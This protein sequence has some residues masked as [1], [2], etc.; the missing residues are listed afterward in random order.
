MDIVSCTAKIQ[1]TLEISWPYSFGEKATAADIYSTSKREC[2]N[3][4][5]ESLSKNNVAYRIIGDVIP[6][7]VVLPVGPQK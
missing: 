3:L 1:V 6:M 7:M 4:L 5:C 2:I